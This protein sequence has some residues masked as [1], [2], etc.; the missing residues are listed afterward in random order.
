MG[1]ALWIGCAVSD[2]AALM[3][4]PDEAL[5][6][7]LLEAIGAADSF[8]DRFEA[9]VWLSDMAQRLEPFIP[10]A[11]HR[12]DLLRHVHYE[13]RRA[14][15]PAELVIAVIEVESAFERFA[16]SQVG[17]RG[18]MQ[19]MPFWLDEIGRDGDDLFNIRTNLR[20]GCTILRY[21]LDRE[22]GDLVRALT[23]YNGSNH[24]TR[25][26]NKVLDALSQRW[27]RQ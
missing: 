2:A 22:R 6:A 23:R 1:L 7:R 12:L 5:R 18:L 15:L 25:Y 19:I 11:R 26:A 27:Y 14:D 9:E 17:A 4:K 21:Y 13:A 10:E 20:M 3:E 24:D 8:T 16:I